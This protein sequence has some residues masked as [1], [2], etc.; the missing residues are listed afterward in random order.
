MLERGGYRRAP[1]R[2]V[3]R[4]FYFLVGWG[5]PPLQRGAAA[6]PGGGGPWRGGT[7]WGEIPSPA[8][9]RWV[10]GDRDFRENANFLYFFVIPM[11]VYHFHVK[12]E[13]Q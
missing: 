1:E 7:R 9:R 4:F 8:A 3:S 2:E 13:F 10:R 12:T 5:L 6:G 11:K